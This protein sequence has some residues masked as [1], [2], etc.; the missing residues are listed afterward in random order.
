MKVIPQEKLSILSWN[1]QGGPYFPQ[2]NF[3]RIAPALNASSAGVLCLQESQIIQSHTAL[4]P[5]PGVYHKVIPERFVDGNSIHSRFPIEAFGEIIFPSSIK[6][7]Y[8]FERALWA[9]IRYG[10]SIIR[11][12]NCHLAIRGVGPKERAEQF[13]HILLHARN[14]QGPTIVCG[15][16]NTTIPMAGFRRRIVQLFHGEPNGSMQIDG[17][18]FS[19]DERYPFVVLARSEGFAEAINLNSSTWSLSPR[20]GWE[21]FHLKLDWFFVRNF[22][23]PNITLGGYI[24]DHRLVFATW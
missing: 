13:Q 24:S 6:L 14:H 22:E 11:I 15:D 8:E 1:I 5:E 12:Y 3:K 21:V 18:L 4:V 16:M 19:E 9:D 2:T 17:K 23:L 10:S 7:G 20:L